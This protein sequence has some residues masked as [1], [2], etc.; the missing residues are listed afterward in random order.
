MRI[1][2]RTSPSGNV[3]FIY[4]PYDKRSFDKL[5][6]HLHEFVETCCYSSGVNSRNFAIQGSLAKYMV[7]LSVAFFDDEC[8][9]SENFFDLH[10]KCLT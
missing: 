3:F 10:G 8:L 5:P 6:G 7:T 4:A 2:A 9:V 1:V